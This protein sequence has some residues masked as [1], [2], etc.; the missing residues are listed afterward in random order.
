MRSLAAALLLALQP[1]GLDNPTAPPGTPPAGTIVIVLPTLA[2]V[3]VPTLYAN[4]GAT[5]ELGDLLFLRLAELGP[6]LRTGDE[7]AFEP[8]LARRWKRR[9]PLTLVFEL[10]PRAR[11]QDGKPV[12]AEDVVFTMDR[13]RN[14]A[15][16]RQVAGLLRHIVKV[17]AEGERTVVFTFDQSYPEQLYDATYHAPPLPSH[18]VAQIPADSLGTSAFARAPVGNGPYRWVRRAL[19]QQTIELKA[20]TTFFL[21]RPGIGRVIFQAVADAGAR[22]NLVLTGAADVVENAYYYSNAAELLALPAYRGVPYPTFN[23][24]FL[25]FNARNP[26]DTSKPHPILGDVEVRRAITE[27]INRDTLARLG[28]GP[29]G[30][31][32]PGPVSQAIWVFDRKLARFP[33]DPASAKRRLAAAGWKENGTG[34]LEKGGVPLRLSLIVPATSQPKRLMATAAQE[35]LRQVGIDLQ[36]LVLAP[37]EIGPRALSGNFDMTFPTTGQDPTPSGLTQGWSCAGGTNFGKYCNP[38]VDSLYEKAIRSKDSGPIWKEA[39]RQI[40]DDAPGVW[41]FS[42]TNVAL[43]HRRFDRVSIRPQSQ[44]LD[45]WQWRLRPEAALPRDSVDSH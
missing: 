8:R 24:G 13:A 42:L 7:S 31:V 16:G 6:T 17:A 20:D 40:V 38:R 29:S 32:P 1:A 34:M 12:T 14:P 26:A 33:F 5:R 3:P 9:D 37:V 2:N 30:V 23:L 39:L 44:W 15:Y 25:L 27:A 22:A 18:L 21:G 35:A 28:F 45:L 10:D 36:L 4:D 41:V 43:V 19:D 11:W